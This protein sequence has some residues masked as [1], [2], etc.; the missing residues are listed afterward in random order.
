M[1]D[2]SYGIYPKPRAIGVDDIAKVV[3]YYR[4]AAINAIEAG[5]C[6]IL[7]FQMIITPIYIHYYHIVDIKTLLVQTMRCAALGQ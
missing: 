7:F 4:I 5:F 3:D 6:Y 2:G 1:P